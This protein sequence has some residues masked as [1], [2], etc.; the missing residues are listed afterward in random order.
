MLTGDNIL[1]KKLTKY[2]PTKHFTVKEDGFYGDFYKPKFDN[3]KGKA[4]IVVGGAA[5]SYTLTKMMAEKFYEKGM[6]VLA[7]AYRDVKGTPH[8]L[9]KI[10]IEYIK[11]AAKWCKDNVALKIG[12]WGISL[13]GQLALISAS[14]FND[15]I[16][17]VVV[18]NPMHYSQQGLKDFKS[19]ELL[20]CA[21][22]TYKGKDLP[23][24]K[25][26][27]SNKEFHAK[28]KQDSRINH[29]FKYLADAYKKEITQMNEDGDYIIKVE[30]IKGPV[31]LLSAGNDCL[32]PS[33]LI[34]EKLYNR[35]ERNNFKYPYKHYNYEIASHYLLPAKPLTT[36]MFAIER[37]YPRQC[38]ENRNKSFEDTLDFLRKEWK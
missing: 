25:F 28:I 31:L 11:I 32:L 2:K 9:S 8:S 27:Q 15:L 33:K 30:N 16:D 24:Y 7:L 22:F 17:A 20:D 36:K 4:M 12:I 35:L 23:Y 3:Y 26:K 34:C 29:E 6:N 13:K 5:G 21:C 19:M 18:V 1:L 10:P 38:D 37:K 14:I